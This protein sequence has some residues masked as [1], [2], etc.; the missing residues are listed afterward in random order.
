MGDWV[1]DEILRTM[2]IMYDGKLENCCY[3]LVK[4]KKP[5]TSAQL[6]ELTDVAVK[7]HVSR[8]VNALNASD[9]SEV[10]RF[11][12]SYGTHYI[13]SYVTGNFIYQVSGSNLLLI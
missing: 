6:D 11:M 1:V 3:V 9:A 10:R 5:H 7:D 12:K 2:G 4:W 13:D 8:A